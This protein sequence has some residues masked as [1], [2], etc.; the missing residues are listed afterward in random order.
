MELAKILKNSQRLLE[1]TWN[2]DEQIV[3]EL[4]ET[5]HDRTGNKTYNSEAALSYA[6]QLAYYSA[7]NYYTLVQELD[8]GKGYADLVYIPAPEHA[9]KPLILIELKY[10]KDA[11]TAVN[12]IRKQIIQPDLNI[13]VVRLNWHRFALCKQ[14]M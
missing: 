8:T 13:I 6:I 11:Q 2:H 9:D 3:A 10:D 4:I 7:Q 5:A 1:A 12:Q 14:N